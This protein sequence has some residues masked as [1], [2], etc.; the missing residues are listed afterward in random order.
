MKVWF[1]RARAMERDPA[2]S[3]LELSDAA[4]ARRRRRRLGHDRRHRRRPGRLPNGS[5]TNSPI[6]PGP[7]VTT[8]R[9]AEALSI[10]DAVRSPTPRRTGFVVL[11]DTGDTVFGGAAGDSN[12]DPRVDAAA[13]DRGPALVPL[14][15]PACRRAGSSRRGRR[16]GDARPSAATRRRRSHRPSKSPAPCAGRRRHDR[17][18]R[19][20]TSARVRHGPDGDL[21]GRA[22]TMM[23]SE[24]RGSPATC[25]TSTALRHRARRLQDGGSEDRLELPVFR[26]DHLAGDPRRHARARPVG[27][28][29]AAVAAPA[30]P[31]LSARF[32]SPT[33]APRRRSR[34]RG[35][36]PEARRRLTISRRN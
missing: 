1:D 34:R 17:A 36:S 4:L 10:D 2:C 9:C 33:G 22:V 28:L 14:I 13:R 25:P 32:R 6:S 12:R 27:R 19:Q 3:G 16:H 26:A 30:A 29:D 18:H 5:P 11:S 15:A 35:M 8:S 31:D 20:A 7:C 24:L 23:I 21:R